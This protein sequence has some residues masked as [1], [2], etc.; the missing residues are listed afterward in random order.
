MKHAIFAA[1]LALVPAGSA[2]AQD[3]PSSAGTLSVSPV[4]Q[5]LDTPW[6]FDF[7]PDGTILI[8]ER[9]GDLLAVRDGRAQR[10]SGLPEI[11]TRGQGG[12]LDVLVPRDFA[13]SREI[14][15]T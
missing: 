1:V 13:T 10:L 12:L 8:T 2:L 15:L 9:G 7:L 4:V 5:G 3:I 14:F 11:Y 6:S